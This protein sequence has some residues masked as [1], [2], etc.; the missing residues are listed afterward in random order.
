MYSHFGVTADL[1][2]RNKRLMVSKQSPSSWVKS[3]FVQSAQVWWYLQFCCCCF[4][5]SPIAVT[6]NVCRCI[7]CAGKFP[8]NWRCEPHDN[9]SSRKETIHRIWSA[10]ESELGFWWFLLFFRWFHRKSLWIVLSFI[11]FPRWHWISTWKKDH[12]WHLSSIALIKLWM[13]HIQPHET[14]PSPIWSHILYFVVGW[15]CPPHVHDVVLLHLS[16]NSNFSFNFL[17]KKNRP[18]CLYSRWKSPAYAGVIVISNGS[19]TNWNEIVK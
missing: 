12:N 8:G 6:V 9:N 5:F 16:I 15:Y 17:Q 10:Y 13:W 18:T 1:M 14:P 2:W 3:I 7:C 4:S 19:G 11:D